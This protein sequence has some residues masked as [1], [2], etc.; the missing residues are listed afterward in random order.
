MWKIINCDII[1]K[2]YQ[3]E[4]A[5]RFIIKNNLKTHVYRLVCVLK[6]SIKKDNCDKKDYKEFIIKI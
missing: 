4:I 1:N 2:N 6:F 3:N 5:A